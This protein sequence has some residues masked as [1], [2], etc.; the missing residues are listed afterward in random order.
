MENMKERLGNMEAWM[1]RSIQH[2]SVGV[3][4]GGEMERSRGNIWRDNGCEISKL[5]KEKSYSEEALWTSARKNKYTTARYTASKHQNTKV[6]ERSPKCSWRGNYLKE[7]ANRE[8]A[9]HSNKG[10][11]RKTLGDDG[12][13]LP[14]LEFYIQWKHLS[15]DWAK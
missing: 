8:V 6:R 14:D 3:P 4:E 12:N 9:S 5:M 15:G 1:R 13:E 2:E 7:V 10:I 11:Q